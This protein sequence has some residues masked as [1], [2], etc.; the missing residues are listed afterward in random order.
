MLFSRIVRARGRCQYPGCTSPG[1]YDTAHLIGRRYSATRCVE[2][3]AI[4]ACRT[5]HQ[6]IDGWWDEKRK[7]VLATIGEA[8][9]DQLRALAEAGP[10]VNSTLFWATEVERLTERCRA[11]G[12]DTRWKAA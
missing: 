11:L 2:D 8:R 7:V 4:C 3:N 5:H 12:V 1:P 10:S 9:Y 6:L